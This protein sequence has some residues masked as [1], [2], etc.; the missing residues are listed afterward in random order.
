VGLG[1][2]KNIKIEG[3]CLLMGNQHKEWTKEEIIKAIQ[4]FY[5]KN[6]KTPRSNE[7]LG[8]NGLPSYAHTLKILNYRFIEDVFSLCN[9]ERTE[10]DVANKIDK[11][12]GLNKLI[13]HFNTYNKIPTR[14]EFKK[15]NLTP[16]HGWY[17]KNFGSYENACFEAGLVDKPLTEKERISIALDELEILADKLNRCPTVFEY[18]NIKHKGYQRRDLEKHI[19][20]KYND[21]CKKYIPKY[22]VNSNKDISKETILKDMSDMLINNG[23][24]MTY[25]DM[26]DKGLPYSQSIFDSKCNMLFN[27][28]ILH[29]GYTPIGTTTSVREEET[30]L[31]DFN[32]LFIKLKRVPY[33]R[34]LDGIGIAS[35][36]T[37]LSHFGS[38]EN[39]CKLLNIDYT[40]YYKG[41][42][43]G[44]I[45]FDKNGGKCRSFM[46]C[47]ISNY[48]IDNG[49]IFDKETSY[50]EFFV[51]DTR[52]F[53][54]KLSINGNN[55]YVE[56]C[57]MYYPNKMNSDMNIAYVKKINSKIKDLKDSGN[58]DK[59]LFIFPDDIKTKTL[60]EIFEPFLG[61]ELLDITNTYKINTV[62]YFTKTSEEL[63]DIIMKYSTNTNI[64]PST[65]IISSKE[66]GAYNEIRKRFKTYN[67]FALHFGMTTMCPPNRKL[68]LM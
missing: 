46:E 16:A 19:N 52:R 45:C 22:Q 8:K 29:L 36:S 62:E 24:A 59:C 39:I 10:A 20:M 47:V 6:G 30:M 4:D 49:L 53:D 58:Y 18:E 40:K 25:D 11:Q 37:Y 5:S 7:F 27:E 14:E 17:G 3:V 61:I 63:L 28:I 56:Y 50:D 21:I 60:K 31:N 68:F 43:A 41:T 67:N 15:Y 34:D 55:F 33:T 54:W 51:K 42:G 65:S 23:G 48:Y 38:V 35:S 13:E 2:G 44:K 9:L 32:N 64:L 12:W 26:K 66:G 1:R 57:G